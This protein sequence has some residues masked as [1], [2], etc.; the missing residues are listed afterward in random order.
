M[1]ITQLPHTPRRRA[2]R[3]VTPQALAAWRVRHAAEV[4]AEL[5]EARATRKQ[6]RS[7]AEPYRPETVRIYVGMLPITVGRA[8]AA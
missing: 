1:P 6:S 4:R 3:P 8:P 5:L 7:R 2:R